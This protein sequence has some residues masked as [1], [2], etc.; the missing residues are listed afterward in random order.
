MF[1]NK[2]NIGEDQRFYFFLSLS[3]PALKTILPDFKVFLPAIYIL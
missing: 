3:F 2:T 1:V